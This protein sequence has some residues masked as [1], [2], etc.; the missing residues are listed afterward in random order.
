[1]V[2][3]LFDAH[4]YACTNVEQVRGSQSHHFIALTY[5]EQDR[6]VLICCHDSKDMIRQYGLLP[7]WNLMKTWAKEKLI[8][9][10]DA[11]TFQSKSSLS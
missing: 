4:L 9:N 7:E 3:A 5:V 1:M 11:G 8:N 6:S 10:D 2:L